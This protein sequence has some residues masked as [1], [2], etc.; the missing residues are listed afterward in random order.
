MPLTSTHNTMQRNA[1]QRNTTQPKASHRIASH[2]IASHP[3]ASHRIASHRIATR[4][5]TPANNTTPTHQYAVPNR[6]VKATQRNA[7]RNATEA[8]AI[9]DEQTNKHAVAESSQHSK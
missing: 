4:A 2:R 9:I 8:K 7:Q 3:I 5:Y 6:H 1:T